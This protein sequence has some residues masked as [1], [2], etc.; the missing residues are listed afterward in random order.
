M[1]HPFAPERALFPLLG[2]KAQLSSCSQSALSTPVSEAL[3][4][5]LASWRDKGMDWG[6]W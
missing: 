5:Y 1:Q 3:A 4:R 6:G 2:H